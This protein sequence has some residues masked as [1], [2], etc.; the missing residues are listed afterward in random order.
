MSGVGWS[1]P[2]A[3]GPPGIGAVT[4]PALRVLAERYLRIA[5]DP[6]RRLEDTA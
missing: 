3:E 1:I 6:R 4:A 5:Q 2:H